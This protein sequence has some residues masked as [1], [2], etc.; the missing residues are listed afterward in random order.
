MN[1]Y[2]IVGLYDHNAQ[3]YNKIKEAFKTN[4]EVAIVHATGTGKS[5]NAIQYAYDNKDK[6]IIYVVP[7]KPII[8]HLQQIIEENPKLTKDDFKHVEFRTYTSFINMSSEELENLEVDALILDEFH[9]IGAPVWGSRIQKIIDTHPNINVLGMTA[10]TVRDRGTSY[11]RDMVNPETNEL[12]SNKVASN[13]DLCD[14]MID[15]VLPKPIYKSAYVKLDKTLEYLE[16]KINIY[17][18]NSKEYQELSKLLN[19]CKKRIH[20]AP[21]MADVFKNNIKKDGKYIY[22]CPLN[23]ENG[24]NDIDTIQNEVKDWLIQMGLT[25]TDYIL[26]TTTS[27]MGEDGKKNRDAFYNDLDLN[28]ET[29][30]GKL[31][32]MFAINQYNEGTHVPNID[33]VIMGRTTQSDIVYFEQLGRALAV[34]GKTKEAFDYYESKSIEELKEIANKRNIEL[35]DNYA[36]DDII[37][38][39]LAPT[40]ID[41]ANNI[42]FIKDLENNLKDRLKLIQGDGLG[43]ARVSHISNAS[44]DIDMLNQDIFEIIKYMYDRMT[45]TWEDKYELAKAYYEHYGN[46]N[47]PQRFKTLN[48]YDYDENGVKLGSWIVYQRIMYKGPGSKDIIKEQI[49]LLEQIGMIWD[50][51]ENQWQEN[52]ELAK[53]YYEHNGNLKIPA[54]F[55]TLNG[56]DYD[57]NGVG[58]GE[59]ISSQRVR[60]KGKEPKNITKER[61]E[62]LEKIGMIWN[63]QTNQWQEN[64][65]L[66]KAYYEHYG[67][68]NIPKNF[69]TLNGY[70]YDEKGVSLG[71]WI[72]NKRKAYKGI[73]GNLPKEQIELLEKIG[74]IWNARENQWQ[75]NYKL[76]KAYYEHHSN[77]NVP[78]NFKTTNGY[79]YDKNGINIYTWILNQ[80]AAYKEI[81]RKITKEQIELLEKIGMKWFE[82]TKD[83]KL[84]EEI[85]TEKNKL[86]KQK[87]IINRVNSMISKY[88][89]EELPNKD[90]INNDFMNQLNKTIK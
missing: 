42:E 32:I 54:N 80:R 72:R 84:Q 23:S 61:I 81:N 85:I 70:D 40:V 3:S 6:K 65:E 2:N 17:D 51:L 86:K 41:L 83:N 60:Y 22:F 27:Q 28:N 48:G 4:K 46:L 73:K 8:E 5:F 31:R 76:V 11:E 20:E 58:L 55:K 34:R 62:L 88:D 30:D 52:Y 10:Y 43:S 19:D 90:E 56:Y 36:K 59:W 66:A 89:G 37:E 33:G 14:A 53:V 68:L 71:V 35:K 38:L 69:K 74:M 21:S 39:L 57:E 75:E 24:I 87:E 7:Y 79:D 26:Y 67:N 78:K 44:F 18:H 50:V 16:E 77:L 9:H 1:E 29:V 64:Y 15:R 13:Y 49:E 25:E 47:M 82:E 63:A 45:M 12:F